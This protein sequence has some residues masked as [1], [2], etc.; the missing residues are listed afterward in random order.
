MTAIVFLTTRVKEPDE[1]DWSKLVK[2]LGYL[3]GTR[4]LVLTLSAGELRVIRWCPD[5]AFAVHKDM[6]SHMGGTMYMGHGS[7]YSC[8][9]KQKLVTK[10]STKVEIVGVTDV[11]PQQLW[12]N[13]FLEAQGCA[14]R[15]SIMYQDNQSVIHLEQHGHNSGG[16]RMRHM[17]M[18]FFFVTNRQKQ[19]NHVEVLPQWGDEGGLLF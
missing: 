19:G 2:V 5:S 18:H 15:Q 8:S 16:N 4:D 3:K 7:V 9:N 12:T 1:D 14:L 13:R 11:L 10:S 17:N 6:K